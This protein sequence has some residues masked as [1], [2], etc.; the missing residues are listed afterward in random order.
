MKFNDVVM[1]TTALGMDNGAQV[2]YV[3]TLTKEQAWD[4]Y[5]AANKLDTE[6]NAEDNFGIA[7]MKIS[8]PTQETRVRL[9]LLLLN[10][11]ARGQN[12]IKSAD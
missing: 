10:A 4:L 8:Q 5:S 12:H 3:S 11:K 1:L 9:N 2:E 7:S 6:V